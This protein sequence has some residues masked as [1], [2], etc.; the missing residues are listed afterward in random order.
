M[1]I[2]KSFSLSDFVGSC[3]SFSSTGA[4]EGVNA[5][6]SEDLISLSE[7]ELVDCDTTNDGCDGGN[8]DY[9]FAWVINNGGI[10]TEAN[11][12]YTGVD[13]T[14]NVTKVFY[15]YHNS[16]SFSFLWILHCE[17]T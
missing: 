9:A 3:W 13:G 5:I 6:V 17:R 4:I 11:Y 12:P 1:N 8:M 14:C 16:P 10:D 7:Q 2:T 15:C